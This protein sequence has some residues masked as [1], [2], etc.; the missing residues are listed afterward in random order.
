MERDEFLKLTAKLF[1]EYGFL[2]IGNQF[3]LNLDRVVVRVYREGAR[4]SPGEYCYFYNCCFKD[5]HEDYR[6]ETKEDYKNMPE[7]LG[8]YKDICT[9]EVREKDKRK[10]TNPN[11]FLPADYSEGEWI[12]L[13][14]KALHKEFD[15]FRYDFENY[16]RKE[17]PLEKT[18]GVSLRAHKAF[19]AR[20]LIF[21]ENRSKGPI[22][23]RREERKASDILEKIQIAFENCGSSLLSLSDVDLTGDIYKEFMYYYVFL[24][25]ENL[26]T[27]YRNKILSKKGMKKSLR[28]RKL[29]DIAFSPEVEFS[30]K[31]VR[32]SPIWKEIFQLADE[33]KAELAKFHDKSKDDEI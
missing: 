33:V 21:Y 1:Q 9:K 23:K 25:K 29:S 10:V 15:P 24:T 8:V 3:F 13:W 27:L 4:F 5:I 12:K 32:T 11:E 6:F 28:I 7:D 14:L 17:F 19:V 30:A 20:G 2:K 18:A 26:K 16:M 22:R 31:F